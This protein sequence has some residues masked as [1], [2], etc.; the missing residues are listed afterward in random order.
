VHSLKRLAVAA[1]LSAAALPSYAG[2]IQYDL[3]DGATYRIRI[4]DDTAGKFTIDI[5]V[6]AGFQADV[7][8]FGFNNGDT[9][10]NSGQLGLTMITPAS[11]GSGYPEFYWD[12]SGC[13][14]G[15]NFNGTGVT[16][17]TIIKFQAPGAANGILEDIRFSIIRPSGATLDLFGLA[18]IR[19]QSV[20]TE[21]CG[22]CGG[23]DKA[24]GRPTPPTT[25]VP[26]PGSLSLLGAGLIGLGLIRRRRPI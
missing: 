2:F 7:L 19:A 3:T 6:G 22:S 23:S 12:T 8:A 10:N 11:L 16:F 26:E 5:D 17:D 18:G 4:D 24:V 13:G 1:L 20:G 21:P 25:Q 9:Y 14:T 15:C